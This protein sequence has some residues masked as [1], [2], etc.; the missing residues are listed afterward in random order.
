MWLLVYASAIQSMRSYCGLKFLLA[1]DWNTR[2]TR[3]AV[4]YFA[5][6]LVTCACCMGPLCLVVVDN[7]NGCGH[8]VRARVGTSGHFTVVF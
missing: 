8:Q 2:C 7:V 3:L 6:V 1:L 5:G 4:A